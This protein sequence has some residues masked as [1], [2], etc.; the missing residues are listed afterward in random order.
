MITRTLCLII[1]LI[2]QSLTYVSAG[3]LP[4]LSGDDVFELQFASKPVISPDGRWVLY[5]H[6]T[7]DRQTDKF[8][9]NLVCHNLETGESRNTLLKYS[10]VSM[11]VW[12]ADSSHYAISAE[13][14]GT[15]YILLMRPGRS[16]PLGS[17]KIE[18][19]AKNLAW[20]P[21]NKQLIFNGFVE[22]PQKRLVPEPEE[23]KNGNWASTVTEIQRDI[24]RRDGQGYLKHGNQQ[25]FL[26][27]I[28]SELV[29]QLTETSF[30]H[31]GPFSWKDSATVYFSGQLFEDWEHE[32]R[33]VIIY[34]INTVHGE[35]TPVIDIKGPAEKPLVI[36]S[37]GEVAFL[38]YRDDGSSYQ[39]QDLFVYNRAKNS[40]QNVTLDFDRD[41]TD[42]QPCND[43]RI[44]FRYDDHG[45]G[46][47]GNYNLALKRMQTDLISDVGGTIIGRPYPGG[48]FS[49]SDEGVL[50]YTLASP[51]APSE[52]ATCSQGV[53]AKV[54]NV[55][56]QFTTSSKIGAVERFTYFSSYD[57]REI[58]G[59]VVYPPDYDPDAARKY[60]LIL[61]IHGG[62]FA[63]YG[64]RFA[65][66]P[67]LYAGAGYLVVYTNPRGSTS[68]GEEFAQLINHDYPQQ[69][70]FEDLMSAVDH[71]IAHYRADPNR[72]YV[73]GGSGGGILTAW[74]VTK[75][76]RFRA[77]VSQKPVINWET[78][79]YTSDGYFY[80][81]KYWFKGTPTEVASEYRRRSP[82]SYVD[83]VSTPT[84]LMTGEQ[85]WR[86]PITE[87]E[88]FY[89]GL[90]LHGVD[91]ILI[92]VPNSSHSI[93]ARPSRIW[94]KLDYI[95]AWFSRYK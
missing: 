14:G 34:S 42:I 48:S 39:Q 89:Q 41:I 5:T 20:G 55:T 31:T 70:D 78:L 92:R 9:E 87:A 2:L 24:Y 19:A 37:T 52:I 23:S 47:L 94:M 74:L 64:S 84:M 4:T 93:A 38:G 59:W 27:D 83:K 86:T 63:N 76:D 66:E 54:T 44:Y 62:P 11:P 88:Q 69:G 85:D 15:N 26:L 35:I 6:V 22:H 33:N 82:L 71:S 79:A 30:D 67:Q 21:S 72:L 49:V 61:E 40:Y 68:Y 65:M 13:K 28:D 95:T 56:K 73:T 8:T 80:F 58:D 29:R 12:R 46:K 60:P 1:A 36:P 91:T 16:N 10:V 90:K 17:I 32:P 75:T 25:L 81:T 7:A 18:V 51:T 77:A 57:N 53:I 3:E 45:V 50:C 43:G